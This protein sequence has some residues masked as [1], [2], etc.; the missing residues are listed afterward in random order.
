V[1]QLGTAGASSYG[2]SSRRAS[3]RP[4]ATGDG[5]RRAG[6]RC[7]RPCASARQPAGAA[8]FGR[9]G[10]FVAVAS[11]ASIVRTAVP[12]PS[13]TSSSRRCVS[14]ACA[15]WPSGERWGPRGSRVPW[16]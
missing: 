4:A 6:S 5:R 1:P 9:I 2:R 7:S 10:R 13:P 8:R 11:G 14:D 12:L 3:V 16:C 15:A